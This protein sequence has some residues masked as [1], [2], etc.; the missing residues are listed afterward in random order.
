MATELLGNKEREKYILGMCLIGDSEALFGICGKLKKADFFA[1]TWSGKVFSAILD[2]IEKDFP[3]DILTVSQKLK[4]GGNLEDCGGGYNL[5]Q[6]ANMVSAANWDYYCRLQ[7]RDSQ[8]NQIQ[9]V[10]DTALDMVGD[11]TERGHPEAIIKYLSQK[12][13]EINQRRTGDAFHEIKDVG[14]EIIEQIY[15][16]RESDESVRRI[17]SFSDAINE[18][19]NG[20]YATGLYIVG[21][22]P[23]VGKTTFAMTEAIN[24]ALNGK[25]AVFISLEMSR[26]DI[27][28][29]FLSKQTRIE[30]IAIERGRDLSDDQLSAL[31][32]AVMKSGSTKLHI[33]DEVAVDYHKIAMLLKMQKAKGKLDF[34][35]IDCLYKILWEIGLFRNGKTDAYPFVVNFLKDL[36]RQLDIPILLLHHFKKA[37]MFRKNRRPI[38]DDYEY[39]DMRSLDGQIS[40]YRHSLAWNKPDF[41][42]DVLELQ[43][44]DVR[45]SKGDLD[46]YLEFVGEYGFV[47]E[48]DSMTKSQYER[49]LEV[50]DSGGEY[51]ED[52]F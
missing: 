51:E 35:I 9:K 50:I 1:L 46:L 19:L 20:G 21:A 13:L 10:L 24:T 41:F 16:K 5:T 44:R 47:K 2:L 33:L 49:A 22:P 40:L 12:L 36:S 27:G 15:E 14:G 17:R 28:E 26:Y 3:V 8:K 29:M 48:L 39:I 18:G 30:R 23:K 43:L 34:A 7:I 38:A 32:G 25:H 31:K 42:P 6:L 4:E 37:Y 11:L 45:K 52:V